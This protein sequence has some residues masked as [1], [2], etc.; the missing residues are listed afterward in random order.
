MWVKRSDGI[1]ATFE[2][3]DLDLVAEIPLAKD[4][5]LNLDL[6][7]GD[8]IEFSNSEFSLDYD[9]CE[10]YLH[11]AY[12]MNEK[13]FNMMW[14]D[15]YK[16]CDKS[17]WYKSKIDWRPECKPGDYQALGRVV[18]DIIKFLFN[19]PS[20]MWEKPIIKVRW[21]VIKKEDVMEPKSTA[22][23]FEIWPKGWELKPVAV[24]QLPSDEDMLKI[25]QK[26]VD[27]VESWKAGQK[28]EC[29]TL[30][31]LANKIQDM[32][33][34]EQPQPPSQWQW[35]GWWGQWPR[36]FLVIYND[37]NGYIENRVSTPVNSIQEARELFHDVWPWLK[38]IN[39]LW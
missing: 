9:V 3:C 12:A 19:N 6:K 30:Q 36:T 15:K 24:E 39:I 37:A 35:Q 38:I 14:V 31:E 29:S 11:T 5:V 18:E 27:I 21:K 20:V 7:Y 34:P 1:R 16:F 17:Y 4:Y 32:K 26:A 28:A 10:W 8:I 13:I 25:I 22:T 2:E 33:Q 23:E